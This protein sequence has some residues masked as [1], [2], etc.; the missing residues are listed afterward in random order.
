VS[1]HRD[2]SPAICGYDGDGDV[3][4]ERCTDVRSA[5][6]AARHATS[7]FGGE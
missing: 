5:A 1:Q 3:W 4:I 6:D 7:T 2:D